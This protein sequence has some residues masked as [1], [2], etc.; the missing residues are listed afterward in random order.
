MPKR[1][2]TSTKVKQ[3]NGD[4]QIHRQG[5]EVYLALAAVIG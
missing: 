1:V 2:I 5:Y 3:A 4:A